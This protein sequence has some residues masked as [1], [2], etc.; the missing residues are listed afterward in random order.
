MI[1]T[2]V[3]KQLHWKASEWMVGGWKN[4][5]P[6]EEGKEE[7]PAFQI[8]EKPPILVGSEEENRQ[9]NW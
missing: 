3:K 9:V 2:E 6:V 5:F 1:G 8:N 4:L 7:K